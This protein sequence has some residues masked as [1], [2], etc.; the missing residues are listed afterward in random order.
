[1]EDDDPDLVLKP[2]PTAERPL[3]GLTVLAV[4]DSRFASEALR[5][6]CLRSGARLRRADCIAAAHRHLRVYRPTVAIIDIGLPDGSGL[7]LLSELDQSVPRVPVLLA[8]TG[9]GL[10]EA[11]AA[12]LAAGADGFLPKPIASLAIFQTQLMRFLP[13]DLRP[14]GPRL[15]DTGAVCPDTLALRE[16]LSHAVELLNL[17]PPPAGY[18]RRFLLGVAR[19]AEDARLEEQARKIDAELSADTCA[20]LKTMLTDRIDHVSAV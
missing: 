6:L 17:N 3:L 16:D 15:A 9:A 19:L 13:P 2:R 10:G 12:A 1:M 8:T 18:L 4:E 14:A 20:T 5:L 11:E 7:D